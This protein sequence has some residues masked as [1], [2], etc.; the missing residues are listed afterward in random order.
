MV[1]NEA[2]KKKEGVWGCPAV[3]VIHDVFFPA[4]ELPCHPM[5]Q[6]DEGALVI[7]DLKLFDAGRAV[8]LI[9]KR[10]LDELLGIMGIEDV[11]LVDFKT[12]ALEHGL[13]CVRMV[14][15]F[16]AVFHD[17]DVR[18]IKIA[19][20][21]PMA[22]DATSHLDERTERVRLDDRPI[23]V[24]VAANFFDGGGDEDEEDVLR[25]GGFD[26]PA[27]V[28]T[29]RELLLPCCWFPAKHLVEVVFLLVAQEHRL[30]AVV[31][32]EADFRI[33]LKLCM[34]EV[35]HQDGTECNLRYP[36]A[37]DRPSLPRVFIREVVALV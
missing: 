3:D 22:Q 28:R 18:Y 31:Q 2:R 11:E 32:Q 15:L 12:W 1:R 7:D 16:L 9:E 36:N 25:R 8:D 29:V 23:E 14:E 30:V 20:K 21:Q 19:E 33:I 37:P 26:H 5:F 13:A 6:P 4:G 34:G 17:D 10:F 27:H 24:V 35:M